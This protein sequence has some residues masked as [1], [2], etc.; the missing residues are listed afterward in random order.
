MR[1][2]FWAP[3]A[4]TSALVLG[5][6]VARA[7]NAQEAPLPP[8]PLLMLQAGPPEGGGPA[9]AFGEGV[10]LL[11]FGGLHGG[12]VV[13]NAPF[14]ATATSVQTLADQNQIT[15]TSNLY[16]DGQG[17]VR[18]EVTL[19]GGSHSF[20]VI[21]DP[22]AGKQYLLR[23]DQKIAYEMPGRGMKHLQAFEKSGPGDHQWKGNSG[24]NV[25][26][27]PIATAP[28]INFGMNVVGTQYTRMIPAGQIGN[29][30]PIKI[31]S[32][33]W[34]SPDLQIVV[35]ST[36]SDPRFGNTTYTVTNIQ[37][38]EPA[39]TLFVVPSDYTVQEGGPGRGMHRFRGGAPPAAA[40]APPPSPGD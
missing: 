32:Q 4:V 8:P 17:R 10:E 12:K 11:G 5:A 31:V 15:R 7:Q 9:E 24:E 28:P 3:I 34:Y 22:V 26:E 16:R 6:G 25:Q 1:R 27:E 38:Q 18:R 14:S 23:P 21:S 36:H 29:T 19:P 33:R 2:S 30:N 40:P 39:A 37:R 13:K 35:M 20:V